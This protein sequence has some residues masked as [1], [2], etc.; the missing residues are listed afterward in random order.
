MTR[1]VAGGGRGGGREGG[2]AK[3]LSKPGAHCLRS[4]RLAGTDDRLLH[5][6]ARYQSKEANKMR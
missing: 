4:D 6:A 1:S 5:G 3:Y 2:R